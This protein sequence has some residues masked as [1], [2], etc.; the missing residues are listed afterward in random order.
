[1]PIEIKVSP[2]TKTNHNYFGKTEKREV[3]RNRDE[4]RSHHGRATL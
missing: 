3:I 2:K 1:M 4:N